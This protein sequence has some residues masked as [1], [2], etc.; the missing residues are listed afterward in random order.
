MC[1][2]KFIVISTMFIIIILSRYRVVII[3]TSYGLG[4]GF[5]ARQGQEIFLFSKNPGRLLG[6]P[7]FLFSVYWFDFLGVKRPRHEVN[8]SPPYCTKVKID[9]NYAFA[10]CVC[11]HGVGRDN[12]TF[13]YNNLYH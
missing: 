8:Y 2:M 11:L 9:W 10:T 3:V 7:T 12:L 6:S 5:E 1:D 13:F 4:P